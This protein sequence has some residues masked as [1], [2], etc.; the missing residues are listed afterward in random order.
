MKKTFTF[1]SAQSPNREN[2]QTLQK[3]AEKAKAE[4][5]ARKIAALL[6]DLPILNDELVQQRQDNFDEDR[7]R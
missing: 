7:N 2:A 1:D 3:T 5:L 6:G 4:E